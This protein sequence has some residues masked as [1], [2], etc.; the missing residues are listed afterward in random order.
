MST[1]YMTNMKRTVYTI[2]VK[3]KSEGVRPDTDM[4][5]SGSCIVGF[6]CSFLCAC[7]YLNLA[8]SPTFFLLSKLS[9]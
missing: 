1:L 8:L 6:F 5:L 7:F 4:A 2:Y 3:P 9:K